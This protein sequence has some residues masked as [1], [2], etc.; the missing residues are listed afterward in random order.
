[1]AESIQEMI[2]RKAKE[3]VAAEAAA[4]AIADMPEVEPTPVDLAE[5]ID[6]RAEA[7]SVAA[8]KTSE[9]FH[10]GTQEKVAVV[11]KTT[12]NTNFW[13]KLAAALVALLLG[14]SIAFWLTDA[15]NRGD[16]SSLNDGMTTGF[17]SAQADRDAKHDEVMQALMGLG[18]RMDDLELQVSTS[19]TAVCALEIPQEVIEA[20]GMCWANPVGPGH[21]NRLVALGGVINDGRTRIALTEMDTQVPEGRSEYVRAPVCG[22]HGQVRST[23]PARQVVTT[24]AVQT[25]APAA[26]AVVVQEM[27]TDSRW[28][29]DEGEGRMPSYRGADRISSTN[30]YT[31]VRLG[32]QY[33]NLHG[34]R[35]KGSSGGGD[36]TVIV[37]TEE[38]GPVDPESGGDPVAPVDPV[39]N[40]MPVDPQSGGETVVHDDKPAAT[41]DE[42]GPAQPQ[43]GG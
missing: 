42:G 6:E 13:V 12:K 11:D 37:V 5:A 16:L 27:T 31:A 35:A 7:R 14:A 36:R 10:A 15:E 20:D 9:G 2:E 3:A 43:G 19:C 25:A 24:A 33:T 23:T 34:C 29:C 41:Q 21:S 39:D 40:G 26:Q 28:L 8:M 32:V 18:S 17:A 1:M 22:Y 38:G 30:A 4:K